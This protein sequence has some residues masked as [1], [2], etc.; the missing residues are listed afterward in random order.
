[1]DPSVISRHET[2]RTFCEVGA[3]MVSRDRNA[4]DDRIAALTSLLPCSVPPVGEKV[5]FLPG[6][7]ADDDLAADTVADGNAF[8]A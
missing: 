5:L 2:L 3:G 7:L 8:V 6:C 4:K 1:M